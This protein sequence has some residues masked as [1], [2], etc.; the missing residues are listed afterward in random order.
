MTLEKRQQLYGIIFRFMI[1]NEIASSI[2][3]EIELLCKRIGV[4]LVPLSK[5]LSDTEFTAEEI[6]SIWG[7]NDGVVC[8]C[9]ERHRIAYN[10]SVSQGRIRFTICE[11][12]S[13]IILGHTQDNRFNV[14]HQDYRPEIYQQYE[15]EGRI[16]AGLLLCNPK[17]FYTYQRVITPNDL[18][19]ICNITI[20]CAIA[21]YNILSKHKD[22]IVSN[23]VYP[24]L[25]VPSVQTS[26]SFS[27]Y[28]DISKYVA[29]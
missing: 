9:N 16:G 1:D 7:N 29:I 18:S 20:P 10:D 11:E 6:F 12:L 22:E 26:N 5:I 15:E 19:I 25:P 21:R 24:F 23:S 13:H 2:P 14:F 4:D 27:N 8:R 3:F 28:T 17:F